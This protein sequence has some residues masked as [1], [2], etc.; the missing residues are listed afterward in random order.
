[1]GTTGSSDATS[2][3]SAYAIRG[4][5]RYDD[6][7]FATA[8]DLFAT[9]ATQEELTD[10]LTLPA[11]EHLVTTAWSPSRARPEHVQIP[12]AHVLNSPS[13][14]RVVHGATRQECACLLLHQRS[15]PEVPLRL[16]RIVG[17]VSNAPTP[18]TTSPVCAA[19]CRSPTPWRMSA[20]GACGTSCSARP[21]R[22]A[23]SE[24]RQAEFATGAPGYTAIKHQREV[25]TGCF[26]EVSQVITSTSAAQDGDIGTSNQPKK[27]VSSARR[28]GSR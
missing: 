13:I 26:D 18:E 27:V 28:S 17:S 20:P 10:F 15:P 21:A 9:L 6:G 5:A 12:S 25:G 1:M 23:Y 4:A 3:P 8:A 2:I 16:P 19:P 24:P 14:V 22:T 11:Y 7:C